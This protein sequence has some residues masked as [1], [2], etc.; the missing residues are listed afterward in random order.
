MTRW[1]N[2]AGKAAAKILGMVL[3]AA[4]ANLVQAAD[5]RVLAANAVREPFMEIAAAFEKATGHRVLAT[6]SGTA[7]IVKRIDDGQVAD[8]VI[9]G[10]DAIDRMVGNGRL[11][12]DGRVDFARSGIGIAV[13]PGIARPDISTPEAVKA[14]ILQARS[15]AYSSGPSGVYIESLF[16]RMGIVDQVKGKLVRPPPSVQIGDLLARGEVELGFQQISDLLPFKDIQFVGALPAAIQNTT[17]YR[18]ALHPAAPAPEAAGALL[19]FLVAPESAPA[20][21][22]AGLEPG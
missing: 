21:R 19:K 13:R 11:R 2:A 20:I 15:V 16:E 5:I 9:V 4:A 17:V 6:W 7:G 22:R 3:L 10:S 14:A 8:I 1:R 18:G 12:A